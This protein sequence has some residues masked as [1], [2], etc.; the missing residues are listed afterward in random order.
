MNPYCFEVVFKKSVLPN[1]FLPKKKYSLA[2]DRTEKIDNNGRH[3][4]KSGDDRRN[5]GINEVSPKTRV[6]VGPCR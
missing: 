1:L 3:E 4:C 6:N 5:D 2:Y